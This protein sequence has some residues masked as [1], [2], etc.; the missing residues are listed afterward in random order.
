MLRVNQAGYATF[1]KDNYGLMTKTRT[2]NEAERS[3][4][5]VSHDN[6]DCIDLSKVDYQH[7]LYEMGKRYTLHVFHN[8]HIHDF[9]DFSCTKY[10]NILNC[11]K[12]KRSLLH[13]LYDL[14]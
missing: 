5:P 1:C 9:H 3:F 13:D 12:N 14:H 2:H 6:H 7:V 8:L 11:M 10:L 4:K